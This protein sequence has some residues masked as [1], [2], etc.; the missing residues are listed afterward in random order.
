MVAPDIDSV[1]DLR[2]RIVGVSRFG[3]SSDVSTRVA[4]ERFE[5]AHLER[6]PDPGRKAT[7]Q[8]LE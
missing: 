4:L 2:G 7:R 3:A 5:G 8:Y 1:S 6:L